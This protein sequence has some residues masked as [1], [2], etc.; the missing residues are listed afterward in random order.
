MNH[1]E[2]VKVNS[3]AQRPRFA[4]LVFPTLKG[5]NVGPLQ[6]PDV[7]LWVLIPWAL[8]TGY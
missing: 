5:S 6:G 3:R 8:P 7:G 4:G 1:A 2:S